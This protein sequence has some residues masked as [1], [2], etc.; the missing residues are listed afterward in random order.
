MNR[1]PESA[2]WTTDVSTVCIGFQPS[3]ARTNECVDAMIP[4]VN[5]W[6][7]F[8]PSALADSVVAFVHE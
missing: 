8:K 7:I 6:A 4:A 3:V 5:C 2:E 1:E